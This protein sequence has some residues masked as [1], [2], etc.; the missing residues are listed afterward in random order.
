MVGVATPTPIHRRG[1][2]RRALTQ[3]RPDPA[4]NEPPTDNHDAEPEL[5]IQGSLTV[6]TRSGAFGGG[7]WIDL[8]ESIGTT[9]SISS[10]AKAVGLSYKGAWEAVEAMNNLADSP[11][12]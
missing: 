11:L 3:P 7:R 4:M 6:Q 5:Q 2:P 8:L 10:A 9:R 12:V 1:N